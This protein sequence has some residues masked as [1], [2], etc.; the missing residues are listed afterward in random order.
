MT[1]NNTV[2]Y[3]LFAQSGLALTVEGFLGS[4][5][6]VKT[7]DNG[8]SV[9]KLSVAANGGSKKQEDG[10]YQN[11][12][13]WVTLSV[14]NSVDG[15]DKLFALVQNP[16][17]DKTKIGK[18]SLVRFEVDVVM[19]LREYNGKAYCD[20]DVKEVKTFRKVIGS[21]GKSGGNGGGSSNN[22]NVVDDLPVSS[23]DD[24]F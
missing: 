17:S 14:W 2:R 13:Q 20:F 12:T 8:R 4:D 10:S 11:Q 16:S 18:G 21:S 19:Q 23:A 24:N 7:V 15:A 6:E 9:M 22:G 5:P 3:N 1:T